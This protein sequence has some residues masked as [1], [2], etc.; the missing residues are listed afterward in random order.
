MISFNAGFCHNKLETIGIAGARH[1]S[2]PYKLLSKKA[3]LR[4]PDGSP[5]GCE[6][7][8][9]WKS[10]RGW[11]ILVHNQQGPQSNSAY[12]YSLD[13]TDWTL[14][15]RSPYNCT[16]HYTDGSTAEAS[17]CGNRPQI[18]FSESLQQGGAPRWLI[19]GAEAA[20]PDGGNGTWTLF[21]KLSH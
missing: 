1:W 19:N 2:G 20:K 18:V 12:G 17:G 21:R 8:H 16:L 10:N 6:D 15:P 7:P 5:H 13:A 9:L 3:I 11:H 4:N 14:S